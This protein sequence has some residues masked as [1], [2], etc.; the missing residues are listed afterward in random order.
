MKNFINISDLSSG[1][2]R[3]ILNEAKE[4]KE[5]RK[6]YNKSAPD[7]DKPFKG[8]SMAMI[9]EKPSTRTRM[10]FDIAVKQLGGSSI[11]L[12]PD[13]IHY[14]KGDETLK[15]TA[16][17]LTEY[18]D[19]V[20]LRTSSHSNLEEFGKHLGIPIINGL[21]EQSHPCQIMSDIL[22]FEEKKGSIKNKVIS[23]LGDGNNNMSNSL[24]EAAG[25]FDFQ[26][27]IGCPT[28]FAPNKKILSWAKKN[29]V[30]L[31]V[32]KN[33]HEAV[34]DADCVM[35]D[36]WISMND[37]V[38]KKQKKKSLKSYQVN[39]ILMSK[40]KSDAIFMHCLPVGRGEEVT[41]EIIDGKKSVVWQQALNRVHAQKSIINWCLN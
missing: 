3:L 41:D 25:K 22:T 9:F 35:T 23:W 29:K 7:E 14:G 31:L 4:R 27:K 33:P 32:T 8:K 28:K 40:A 15:D 2:L 11:I 20:M 37:K 26:L 36:K 13:G 18:V 10:S 19:I 17:V 6:N 21:S 39:K 34:K 5:K 1:D 38:N 30:D 16:K 24:I 12:N